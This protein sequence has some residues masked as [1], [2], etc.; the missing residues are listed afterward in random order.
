MPMSRRLTLRRLTTIY[1]RQDNPTWGSQYVPS[2]LAT[3]GE[4]PSISNAYVVRSTKF[5][6]LV[7]LLST[8]ELSAFV[9]A[10]Y[11]PA[12]IGFQ[13]QRMLSPEPRCHP[14]CN[15]PEE[16][17][18][19]LP[20][21]KGVIDVADRLGYLLRLPRVKAPVS[22]RQG[23]KTDV[24]FPYIGDF[25][26]AI[27]RPGTA[28][29]CVNWSIKADEAG[30]KRPIAKAGRNTL[31]PAE[32]V[33]MRH[34]IERT[35]YADAGI[36]THFVASSA[37]DTDVINNLR[38]L[39][40]YQQAT[41]D[42]NNHERLEMES[43]FTSCLESGQPISLL[44]PRLLSKGIQTLDVILTCFY[45]AIWQ[46]RLRVDLFRPILIDRPLHPEIRDVLDTY[47]KLFRGDVS[48]VSVAG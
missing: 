20:P 12:L 3:R 13:E 39:Y 37:F 19:S 17:P 6:R 21:L 44:L 15:M 25:L 7:H 33:L 46:R 43:R 9:L 11:H 36:H 5:G 47:A 34:E 29:Q 42:M 31:Q 2:I 16:V 8:S 48:C 23:V 35:Y 40:P 26:L 14:L 38:F 1:E 41:L 32:S 27:R 4:A 10:A 24:V 30:F 45:Q 18:A 22:S 28:T